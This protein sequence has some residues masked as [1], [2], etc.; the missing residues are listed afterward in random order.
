[1]QKIETAIESAQ[2]EGHSG[3]C[4]A[5]AIAIN[6]IIFEGQ[7]TIVGVANKEDFCE[8]EVSLFNGHIAVLDTFGEYWD[9]MGCMTEEEF[10]QWGIDAQCYDSKEESIL[11]Q[12]DEEEVIDHLPSYTTDEEI[13][14]MMGDLAF[15]LET[16]AGPLPDG[17]PLRRRR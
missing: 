4:G 16:G 5:A 10:I 6:R 11:I 2:L 1:M 8:W 15:H 7:G 14:G 9:E 13:I 12:L 17:H 3:Y